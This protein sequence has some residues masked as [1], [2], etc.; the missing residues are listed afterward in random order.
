MITR[1]AILSWLRCYRQ[2]LADNKDYLTGLDSA[3]GDA[4]H[5]A[6]MDRGFA[7]VVE[8]LPTVADKDIGTILKTAG[9]TLV[10]MQRGVKTGNARADDQNVKVQVLG[11]LREIF[12]SIS[13][14]KIAPLRKVCKHY[15]NNLQ[16]LFQ[17]ENALSFR[18]S[19]FQTRI[20]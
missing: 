20:L 1:D 15:C 12:S 2:A 16:K 11:Q 18:Q 4:D 7:A 13:H 14:H 19:V 10:Y 8:K 17:Q 6:N 5:G 9:M 3:I